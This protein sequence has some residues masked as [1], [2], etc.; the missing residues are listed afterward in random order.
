MKRIIWPQGVQKFCKLTLLPE[1][2]YDIQV[3][4]VPGPAEI[5]HDL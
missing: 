2:A 4:K 1:V 5:L 3:V